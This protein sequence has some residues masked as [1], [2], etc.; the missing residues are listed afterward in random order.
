MNKLSIFLS[1]VLLSSNISLSNGQ[2]DLKKTDDV[3]RIALNSVMFPQDEP[4]NSSVEKAIINKLNRIT[5]KNG[6]GG[7]AVDARFIITATT[8]VLTKDIT[9]TAPP[10]HVYNI[11]TTIY[12]GDGLEGKLFASTSIESKGVGKTEAKA[13]MMAIKSIKPT[14]DVFEKLVSDGSNKIIEYYNATCD[15]ILSEAKA[16]EAK[17]SYDDAIAKCMSIPNVCKDCYEESMKLV[18]SIFQTKIDFECK[19]IMNQA[20]GKWAASQDKDGADATIEL[21]STIDPQ[22]NCFKDATSFLDLIY[23]EIKDKI[24]EIEQKE[25]DLKM[26]TQQDATDLESQRLD[27]VKEVAKAYAKNRPAVNYYVIY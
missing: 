17:Q 22:S 8:T 4:L 5:S 15:L 20:Q 7:N 2:N 12:I 26:K 21:L 19:K 10:M 23:T 9:P 27:A 6:I 16:L 11:E 25:W 1:I 3:G 18:G 14:S 24:D 13:Y